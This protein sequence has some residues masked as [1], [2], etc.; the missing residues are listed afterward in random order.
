MTMYNPL[1]SHVKRFADR[2]ADREGLARTIVPGLNLIRATGSGELQYAINRPLVALVVQGEKRVTLGGE[3]HDLVAGDSMLISADV[4]TISQITRAT[5]GAPYY[6]FVLELDLALVETLVSE[7]RMSETPGEAPLR[8]EPTE[9]E[10]ADAALRLLRLFDRPTAV[11]ILLAQLVRELH[12]WLLTGKHGAAIRNLGVTGSH[13]QRI[14]RAIA[15]IRASYDQPLGVERL[16]EAAGM[17][18][19]SFH[20]HFR[21]IT[22]L[23]PLQFQK[24]LRLIEARRLMLSEGE[25]ASNAAY[26]VGYESVPQF[27]REYGRLFGVPPVRDIKQARERNSRAA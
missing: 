13:A 2:D 18:V 27:T 6:S 5:T 4:P 7:M 14:G 22:S 24:Q 9:A 8:I 15:V 25:A 11:P 26:A 12:F 1:L 3:S 17:S 23:S 19:S 21:A 16:A 20:Q 10:V